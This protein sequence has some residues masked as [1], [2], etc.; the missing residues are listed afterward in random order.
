MLAPNDLED[1]A[2][3]AEDG[4]PIAEADGIIP[5][6]EEPEVE[7]RKA[8]G[9]KTPSTPSAAD[10]AEHNLTH[11]H[12]RSWCPTC[13]AA[14]GTSDPHFRQPAQDDRAMSTVCAD[15][16]FMCRDPKA[17][18]EADKD[19]DE[20]GETDDDP[21]KPSKVTILTVEDSIS[22]CLRPH[23]VLH[24]GTTRVPWIGKA[25]A[26]DMELWGHSICVFK[27]DQERAIMA[28]FNAIVKARSPLKT[29][30]ENSPKG[31]SQ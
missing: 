23:H 19:D 11:A 14:K 24:K 2:M 20:D 1:G 28:V 4:D 22:G 26:E 12:F 7:V 27:S 5:V 18:A 3:V 9:V 17:E 29:I 31:D 21:A 25:V 6:P 10:V 13:V 30:P 8:V 15:Y 16:C